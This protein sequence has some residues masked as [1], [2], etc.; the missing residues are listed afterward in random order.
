MTANGRSPTTT[1]DCVRTETAS[2]AHRS[3][4][5]DFEQ[6]LELLSDEYACKLLC[7]LDENPMSASD[8][9]EQC[10]MSR[11]TVYRRL[12][13]MAE[14]GIITSRQSSTADGQQR[15]EYSLV[16]DAVELHLHSD[17]VTG[18]LCSSVNS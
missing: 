15:A 5:V 12:E 10:E 17:G 13:T 8:L 9:V 18:A 16:V 14:A 7:V 4:T 3:R 6:L 1:S 2:S 11:P